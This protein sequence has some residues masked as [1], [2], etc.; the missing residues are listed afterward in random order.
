MVKVDAT[1][2][3]AFSGA[4]LGHNWQQ[5][6]LNILNNSAKGE[7][8]MDELECTRR[9]TSCFLMFVPIRFRG[10]YYVTVDS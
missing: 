5:P 8:R 3:F 10:I 2:P 6:V 7:P 9:G 4:F 1:P